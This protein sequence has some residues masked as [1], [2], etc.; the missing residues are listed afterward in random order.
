[1]DYLAAE[2]FDHLAPAFGTLLLE[3]AIPEKLSPALVE[4][5][6]GE[7]RGAERLAEIE[8]AGLLLA[9]VDLEGTWLRFHN[10]FRQFLLGRAAQ[11]FAQED[12]RRRHR[13]LAAWYADKGFREEAIQHWIEAGET[14]RAAGLLAE[15]VDA[16]LA[17]ER[18]GLIQTYADRLPAEA[19]L[20]HDNLAHAAIIAYGFR[21][22]FDKADR[23]LQ[24]HRAQLESAGAGQAQLGLH[25]FS[26]L[27]V[28]AAQD[29]VEEL[30]AVGEQTAQQLAD[31]GGFPYA[32]TFNS[33][34]LLCIGQ[35]RYEDARALLVQA[36]PLHD[37]DHSLFGQS[38]QDAIYGMSLACQGRID[39]AE[40][41]LAAALRR[42]EARACGSVSAGSVMTAYL[43]S[44][45]YEQNRLDEAERLIGDYGQLAEE[46][47]IADAVATMGIARAHRASGR[48]PRRSGRDAGA[49]ALR[50]LPALA[51]AP[52]DL[53]ARGACT[54]GHAGWRARTGRAM[55]QGTA[56]RVP[57]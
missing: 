30:G 11:L 32:V 15:V 28:L 46:Q 48:T 27:F 55:A 16:L 8:R 10:L 26:R 40:R 54:P 20:R 23:L 13:S 35:G 18:L 53:R 2:A 21:R 3:L 38:Y 42:T 56:R 52:G 44:C 14:D 17:Q 7:P 36:R 22:E 24:L 1:M 4:H 33:R 47:A 12:L 6:T 25:N 19:V 9:Q 41:G 43:V 51:T 37:R 31:R 29:R 39:D 50:R 49:H 45:L 5:I 57:G 34:A